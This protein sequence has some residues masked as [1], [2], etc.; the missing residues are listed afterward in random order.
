M[1]PSAPRSFAYILLVA[2]PL[3]TLLYFLAS[4]P[5]PSHHLPVPVYP[6]LASL[7]AYS[8]AR[9][10]YPEEWAGNGSYV[11]FPM[12]RTQYWLVGP[13]SGKKIVLIHGLSIP[14]L[15]WEPIVPQLTAA[16]YQVLLYD[17]YGRGYSDAPQGATYDTS[18]YLTQLALLL[19]HLEWHRTRIMGV[20]MGGAIAAAFVATF[21]ARV[22]RDVILV[23]SAGLVQSAELSR[24][25]KFMSSPL[26]QTLTGNPLVYAYLRRLASKPE[27]IQRVSSPMNELVRHQSAHLPGYN[28]AISSSLRDGPVTGMH[29]AFAAARQWQGRRVLLVHGTDDHTVPP[30][31]APLIQLLLTT[32]SEASNDTATQPVPP[33]VDIARIP[34]AGHS[35]TWTHA[36]EVGRAVCA[37]LEGGH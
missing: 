35:L 28:R 37:F 24:T 20:S 16:G 14:A 23:A 7:P 34:G 2:P 19:Q 29:W 15:I 13:A 18:L 10:I 26:V 36:E 1:A 4:F 9:A 25:S 8:R 3:V 27:A 21:P 30:A 12:G 11:E 33:Q 5:T 6:G 22:E 17:L 32:P 31:H